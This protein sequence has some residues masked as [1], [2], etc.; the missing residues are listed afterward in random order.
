MKEIS[1]LFF[2]GLLTLCSVRPAPAV[3]TEYSTTNR[4]VTVTNTL[5]ASEVRPLAAY[6]L[7][8]APATA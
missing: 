7:F 6:I 4:A 5:P 8:P 1:I 2:A 3:M